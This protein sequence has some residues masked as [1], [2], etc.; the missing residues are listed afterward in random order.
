MFAASSN[1][2]IA[3][4]PVFLTGGLKPTHAERGPALAAVG[5]QSDIAEK[6]APRP[7]FS[8][9]IAAASNEL[10]VELATTPE[11]IQEVY[12][13]RYRVYCEER[14]YEQS[15]NGLEQDS[16]DERAHHVLV[17][18]RLTGVA[19]GTVRIVLP[20]AE[21]GLASVPMAQV[22][23]NYVFA[24]LPV[25]S[26][27]EVSRFALTRDRTGVSA[28]AAALMRIC[29]FRGVIAV[30]Q[31]EGITHWCAVMEKTLLRLLRTTAVYFEAVG[32]VVEFH[33]LRQPAIVSIDSG[34]KRMQREQPALWAYITD[35]GSL[36]P[37]TT[38]ELQ[39]AA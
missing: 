7:S 20:T 37:E 5:T 29:L 19:L 9:A 15:D 4:F 34:L 12:Q 33:G 28:A 22:C 25:T 8:D 39:Q 3:Q 31:R 27:A 18:S 14:G 6:Q 17:R 21:A 10:S 26:T 32:P 38:E 36:W 35:H 24:S 16:Y 1:T 2:S 23:E 11:Q 30:S 13:L